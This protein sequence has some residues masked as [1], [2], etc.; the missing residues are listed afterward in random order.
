MKAY[1]IQRLKEASTWRG[2]TALLTAIGVTISP[3]QT[4]AVVSAGLALM[5]LL[6]VF[7]KDK[8]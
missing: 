2:L 3:E 8:P 1:L 5:G 7:T 6:G 4:N